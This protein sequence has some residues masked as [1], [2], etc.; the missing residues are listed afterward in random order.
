MIETKQVKLSKLFRGGRFV[1][2]ALSVDGQ[3]L[4]NQISIELPMTDGVSKRVKIVVTF[5]C[6]NEM[7][8]DAPDIHLKS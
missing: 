6:D 5:N 7:A 2:H 3:L 4:S 1:G 8:V